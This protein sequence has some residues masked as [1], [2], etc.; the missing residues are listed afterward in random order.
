MKKSILLIF[1]FFSLNIFSQKII[2][3]F[4]LD[5]INNPIVF[6]NVG[7]LNSSVGTISDD[8]GSFVL[9]LDKVD[10]N[11]TL[12]ISS[13]GFKS[14]DIRVSELSFNQSLGI[15]L[16]TEV[17]LLKELEILSGNLKTYTEG[18]SKTDTKSKVIFANEKYANFNMGTEI[19]RRFD[20]GSKKPSL[21][22]K[23][24]FYIK[25][26]NFDSNTFKVNI[27]GLKNGKPA[28]LLNSENIF[29]TIEKDFTG[30]VTV[31]LEDY[32]LIIQEDIAVCVQWVKYSGNGNILNLP[33]IAP[34]LG[35]IHYYKFGS[36][37]KWEKYGKVSS[38]MKLVY[39]Q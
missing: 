26:N 3:G 30:W 15:N 10:F 38:P 39:Q 6:A 32:N 17:F 22:S 20:I 31:E 33:M 23:F 24:Q 4:V 19:G 27:Y 35:S 13:L 14:R 29:V 18:K 5:S 36:Q 12:R 11:D 37:N 1:F 28:I 25:E 2:Q 7:M 9:N 21:L 8:N 16:E 34:S